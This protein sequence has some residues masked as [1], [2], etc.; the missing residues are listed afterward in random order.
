LNGLNVNKI[1]YFTDK[2]PEKKKINEVI[3]ESV[4][5]REIINKL[6]LLNCETYE[7]FI[8]KVNQLSI[9]EF[10]NINKIKEKYN[11]VWIYRKNKSVLYIKH[12][13]ILYGYDFIDL[14]KVV[15]N[16]DIK[17]ILIFYSNITNKKLRSEK[18]QDYVKENQTILKKTNIEEEKQKV[19]EF[20]N[21]EVKY[22]N[23]RTYKNK[24]CLIISNRYIAKKL[25]ISVKKINKILKKIELEGY[26]EKQKSSNPYKISSY[27]INNYAE[28]KN[29]NFDD[30][31]VYIRNQIETKGYFQ[32][33]ELKNILNKR[34]IKNLINNFKNDGFLY[35]KPNKKLKEK[36]NLNN[37]KYILIKG[38]FKN[39]IL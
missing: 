27:V 20:L 7:E 31:N 37:D 21:E 17:N 24:P 25:N 12:N 15:F 3:K 34:E 28:I 39:K 14:L 32:I 9:L 35:I 8:R 33:E 38:G 19:L 26:I 22:K 2:I 36:Y 10:V 1:K 23:V 30:L 18:W 6:S 4:N 16:T 5:K 11:N 29:N 13:N